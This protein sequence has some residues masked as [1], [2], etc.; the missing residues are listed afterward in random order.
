LAIAGRV[1]A[2]LCEM[3][4]DAEGGST[5]RMTCVSKLD[6]R[7]CLR[8]AGRLTIRTYVPVEQLICSPKMALIAISKI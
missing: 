2:L 7:Q 3:F 1:L 5:S 8:I 6:P 4:A